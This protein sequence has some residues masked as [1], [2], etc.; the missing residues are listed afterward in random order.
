VF[1]PGVFQILIGMAT[2]RTV[3]RKMTASVQYPFRLERKTDARAILAEHLPNQLE[4]DRRQNQQDLPVNLESR[5]IAQARFG[6]PVKTNGEKCQIASFGQSSRRPPPAK[7]QP[8]AKG[9]AIHSRAKSGGRPISAPIVAPAY[10]PAMSPASRR[11]FKRQIRGIVMEQQAGRDPGGQ[12]DAEEQ[13]EDQP[14]G[15]VA[16]L[17]DQDAAEASVPYEHRRQHAITARRTTGVTS[18]T[19][20][21]E[22][23]S[24]RHRLDL[25]DLIGRVN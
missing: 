15:P 12:R 16:A 23:A 11:R 18:S 17:E 1:D 5:T 3:A 9:S 24:V 6:K 8:T 2:P 13:H 25:L 21:G 4:S 20:S 10:G 19:C 7:P 22:E 14:V